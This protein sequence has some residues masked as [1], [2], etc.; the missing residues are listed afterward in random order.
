MNLVLEEE[1]RRDGKGITRAGASISISTF[2]N[3]ASTLGWGGLEFLAGIPGTVGG[4]A[5]MNGGT[6]LGETSGSIRGVSVFRFSTGDWRGFSGAELSYSYRENHFLAADDLVW[7]TKWEFTPSD[8]LLVKTLVDQVLARRK[9][10][11]P[12]E[13]PSCGSVFRNPDGMRAWEV[14][15]KLG[16]RGHRIG[17]AGFSEK[18]PNWILNLGGAQASDVRALIELAKKR[19]RSELG[20][21]LQEE[22]KF[23]G[24][25]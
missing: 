1:S 20:V 21:S 5:F 13:A 22:V 6:H 9:A 8:P 23:L 11:Q 18:H 24:E 25:F 15:E 19:S 16:L 14:I 10:T 3:R 4:V 2:L 12:L 7:E 17:G